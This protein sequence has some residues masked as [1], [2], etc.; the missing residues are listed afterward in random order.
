MLAAARREDFRSFLINDVAFLEA[1][2]ARNGGDAA[3]SRAILAPVRENLAK[4]VADNPGQSRGWS[5]LAR[6]DA[7]L[8]RADDALREAEKATELVPT[9]RDAVVGPR[10]ITQLAEVCSSVAIV[11]AIELL[12]KVSQVPFG[13]SYGELLMPFWD[14]LRDD[15]RSRKFGRRRKRLASR[16]AKRD[17]QR[18]AQ[19]RRAGSDAQLIAFRMNANAIAPAIRKHEQITNHRHISDRCHRPPRRLQHAYRNGRRR[20]RW[21]GRNRRRASGRGGRRSH[22]CCSG[23]HR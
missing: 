11:S 16:V 9:S 5:S 23:G 17:V 15:R 10:R 18:Q 7:Y 13:P 4:E 12:A 8:G 22:W 1:L 14:E 21:H 2:V 3:K 20:R 6:A 19:D